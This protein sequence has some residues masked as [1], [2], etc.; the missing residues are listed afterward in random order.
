MPDGWRMTAGGG[1]RDQGRHGPRTCEDSR[2]GPRA[3]SVHPPVPPR[4]PDRPGHRPPAPGRAGRRRGG[5]RHHRPGDPGPRPA[6]AP[7]PPDLDVRAPP[8]PADP[9]VAV[10]IYRPHQPQGAIVWLHGGG[11]VMGDLDT[12][13]PWAARVAGGCGAVVVSVGYRRAPE[14]R[15]PAALDDAY[16]ALAWTATPA[17]ELG[18]DPG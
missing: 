10:R 14:H 7:D 1:D 5:R 11:F 3:G 13:H 9:E 12:E 18:I 2:H 8:R 17:A 6:A 16:A 4:R 15:F